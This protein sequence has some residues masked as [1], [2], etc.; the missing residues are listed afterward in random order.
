MPR[1]NPTSQIDG[2]NMRLFAFSLPSFAGGIAGVTSGLS[3]GF[4]GGLARGLLGKFHI[5][6]L[7]VSFHGGFTSGS[8]GDLRRDEGSSLTSFLGQLGSFPL[9]DTDI[10]RG[11]DSFP[12][13]SPFGG[14]GTLGRRSCLGGSLQLRLLRLCG[15]A[16]AVGKTGVLRSVHLNRMR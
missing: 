9:G 1:S 14:G 7:L 11:P 6:G 10:A 4:Q 3:L 5:A 12:C 2:S 15:G 16:Q 13:G 8:L